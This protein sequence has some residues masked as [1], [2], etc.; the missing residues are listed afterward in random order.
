[1]KHYVAV[2]HS[3]FI[4]SKGFEVFDIDAENEEAA[5]SVAKSRCY[6]A[7]STFNHAAV[8]VIEIGPDER[9]GSSLRLTWKERISGKLERRRT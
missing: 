6:D 1:M 4:S 7:D 8:T 3:W 9:S 2:I 5:W